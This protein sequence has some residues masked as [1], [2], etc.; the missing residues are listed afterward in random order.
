MRNR[1]QT[2]FCRDRLAND[3][4]LTLKDVRSAW[5]ASGR[6]GILGENA[7]YSARKTLGLSKTRNLVRKRS[8][9]SRSGCLLP[10]ET[11][12]DL[13][14]DT[15]NTTYLKIETELDNLLGFADKMKNRELFESLQR[16]RR[17]VAVQLV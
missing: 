5:I 2:K 6:P 17:L 13:L 9:I 8:S 4:A 7:Y 3:K 15:H 16:S 10:G 14:C 1:G 12:N 11:I